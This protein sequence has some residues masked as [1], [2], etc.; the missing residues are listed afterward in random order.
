MPRLISAL[1]VL[2]LLLW[3][4]SA[5]ANALPMVDPRSAGEQVQQGG[6]AQREAPSGLMEEPV[7]YP[8]DGI[9]PQESIVVA[10][11]D[12]THRIISESVTGTARW[13]D[14][15]F[16]DPRIENEIG[17]SRL[18][19]RFSLFAEE[20]EGTEY[21]V[22]TNLRLHLPVLEDRLHLL[23]AGDPEDE[24]DFRAA[25]G[26]EWHTPELADREE[27]VSASLRYYLIQTLARNVSLRGGLRLRSGTPTLFLEPRFRQSVPL[28]PW[29][30]RFT[31]RFIAFTNGELQARTSF[32]LDRQLHSSL[33]LRTAAE[34]SWFSDEHGY[35]YSLGV[36]LFQPL[37][38]WRVLEYSW[39]NAFQTHPHHRLEE[40][41]LRVR[42][43]QRIWR[44]WLF[45]EVVP[46][47]AFP[48]EKNF[49][50]APG[51]LL[52]LEMIFGD[53]PKLP[54]PA[55]ISRK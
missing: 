9:S 2:M 32:D 55:P 42:Y 3:R 39:G 21:D 19:V 14:S 4:P 30:F 34:G 10:V 36:S 26:S 47:L 22:H 25:S 28:D 23:V 13:I 24:N 15:F 8:V 6:E 43:R 18:K 51:I 44:D 20:E 29:L 40:T 27:A 38:H 16:S 7:E 50:A 31:Q 5:E 41:V 33:F 17:K 37:D 46:Q 53:Y 52:R 48:R 35:F 1:L 45:Y 11:V 54:P 49:S 12:S